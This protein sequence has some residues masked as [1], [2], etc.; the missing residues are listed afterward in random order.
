MQQPIH[1]STMP[2]EPSD[3]A[4]LSHLLDEAFDLDPAQ[5]E[6]W[7]AGLPEAHRDLLPRLRDML[8]EHGATGGNAHQFSLPHLDQETPD[9]A[10]GRPAEQIG[11]YRLIREIGR[12]GMGEVWLAERVDHALKRQVALKLPRVLWGPGLAERMARERDIGALLEHPNIARL[13]DAGLDA[14]GRPYLAFEYID[15]QALD[16][17]CNAQALSVSARLKLCLQVVRAVAYAH[18]RLVVHRDLKPSNVL[19]TRD[20]QAHLLDFGIGKLLD[21]ASSG[22]ASL[23]QEQ[24][25]VLTP[26]YA[27]PEQLRGEAITVASDVYSLG[28][29]LYEMLTGGSPYDPPPNSLAAWEAAVLHG[30]PALASSRAKDRDTASALRGEIDAILAKTL[31]HVP[32]QRYVTA[33]ALAEDIE[34]HLSG[35]R[36]LARPDSLRYRLGKALRRH[37]VVFAAAGAVLIAVFGAAGVSLV[38]AQRASAAADRARVVKEFVVD[39][40][41]INERANPANNELRQLPIELMLEH[42]S[43]LIETKFSGDTQ[44]QAELYGVVAGIFADMASHQ[45]A[46]TYARKQLAALQ[47]LGASDDELARATTMIAWSLANQGSA[48]D[49]QELARHAIDLARGS[50]DVQIEARLA[51]I[52]S[53]TRQSRDPEALAELD[54]VDAELAARA[55]GFSLQAAHALS[56][57]AFVMAFRGDFDAA[58]PVFTRAIDMALA[59]EGPLSRLAI[60]SRLV[61]SRRYFELGRLDDGKPHRAAALAALRSR[62]GPDEIRAAMTEAQFAAEMSASWSHGKRLLSFEEAHATLEKI[63]ADLMSKGKQVPALS[64]ARVRFL[65][66]VLDLSWGNVEEGYARIGPAAEIM[67]AAWSS[68][69]WGLQMTTHVLGVA[70]QQRGDFA[71]ADRLLHESIEWSKSSRRFNLSE[72][73]IR[74][75]QNAWMQGHYAQAEARLASTLEGKS[76]ASPGSA[77]LPDAESLALARVELALER[78]NPSL[79]LELV[80]AWSE[81]VDD[82]V[83]RDRRLLRGAALCALGRPREGLALMETYVAKAAEEHYAFNPELA[84]WRSLVGLCALRSGQR[85]RATELFELS[86]AAFENQRGV[87]PYYKAPQA[88]L[89]AKLGRQP[90]AAASN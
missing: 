26:H 89:A 38:Q 84:R 64:L 52:E 53:L 86:R 12:G 33:D 44:L 20:G 18:G 67:R 60:D 51:L 10:T 3:L 70:E 72:T 56:K 65:L 74:L 46:E 71:T 75:A 1:P 4:A 30:E 73:Y 85:A 62:G 40:F 19:V 79:A 87:S 25:R 45:L 6:P 61:L 41:R 48:R 78:G 17:W 2:L 35:E 27:S 76:Q 13:Y 15:G 42:G 31:K 90:A 49:A 7:L 14:H 39:T 63:E 80:P 43:K 23:T 82:D 36:V 29:L 11:P 66:G 88:Q 57:R 28:V 8:A 22:A 69:P 54:K 32:E 59:I 68:D 16:A 21:D 81:S 58:V 24:G 47:A 50:P 5:V 55:H 83:F 34:R 77:P 37:R 9:G